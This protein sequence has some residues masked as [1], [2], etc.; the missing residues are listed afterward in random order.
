MCVPLLGH[1]TCKSCHFF[2]F[3]SGRLAS[4]LQRPSIMALPINP[5]RPLSWYTR[6]YIDG[7]PLESDQKT[8]LP[9]QIYTRIITPPLLGEAIDTH[10]QNRESNLSVHSTLLLV[11]I[12]VERATKSSFQTTDS[13]CDVAMREN[14]C[15][16]ANIGSRSIES[17]TATTRRT[18]VPSGQ[19]RQAPNMAS[20]IAAPNE[21]K[22]TSARVTKEG[23][24]LT[25]EMNVIQQPQ[26][27]RACGSGAKCRFQS[28]H[29]PHRVAHC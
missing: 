13:D 1:E 25:Y 2:H 4:I 6:I 29:G 21:T 19:I 24:K 8:C 9:K 26:R 12:D 28:S 7:F 17:V 23:K 3:P 20:I 5:S 27:A 15:D 11:A 14:M 10:R 16:E 18:N 22:S